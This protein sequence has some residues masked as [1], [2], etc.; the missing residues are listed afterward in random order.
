MDIDIL[1]FWL[2]LLFAAGIFFRANAPTGWLLVSGAIMTAGVLALALAP[3]QAPW[4]ASG[5]VV[6]LIG[7]PSLFSHTLNRAILRQ[8]YDLACWLNRA[9]TILHPMDGT[10]A[11]GRLL[12]A[13]A[14][15]QRGNWEQAEPLLRA[16]SEN[17]MHPAVGLAALVHVCH[18]TGDWRAML[19]DPRL[20][21]GDPGTTVYRL[22]ALGELGRTREMLA[23]FAMEEPRLRRQPGWGN[24]Q[25]LAL[26]FGG[27]PD[28]VAALGRTVLRNSPAE[29]IALWVATA[30]LAT[31]GAEAETG[32]T[33]L[34]HLAASGPPNV[35]RAAELRLANPPQDLSQIH[36]A[37]RVMLDGLSAALL[38]PTPPRQR[39]RLAKSPA[40]LALLA[41]NLAMFAAEAAMGGSENEDVLLRLGAL[42]PHALIEEGEWW[43]LAS[44]MFLHAG[45]IHLAFN[46]LA[47]VLLGGPVEAMFGRTRFLLIYFL[48][49]LGSML[50]VLAITRF[51][52]MNGT[53]LVGA[54]GALMGLLGAIGAALL[55]RWRNERSPAA[56]GRLVFGAFAVAVQTGIDFTTPQISAAAHL[57]GFT[58]GFVLCMA[59]WMRRNMRMPAFANEQAPAPQ[60]P[61]TSR[62]LVLYGFVAGIF[63]TAFWLR[64][65]QLHVTS[66]TSADLGQSQPLT[67]AVLKG[68]RLLRFTFIPFV[69]AGAPVVDSRAPFGSSDAL[70][71]SLGRDRRQPRRRGR[72]LCGDHGGHPEI[73]RAS[74]LGSRP[75]QSCAQRGHDLEPLR[76]SSTGLGSP[77]PRRSKPGRNRGGWHVRLHCRAC[78][79]APRLVLACAR[80]SS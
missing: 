44:A 42:W 28:A 11:Q 72:T 73:L 32:R 46:M 5:L 45:P 4:I 48:S 17:T 39:A 51:G 25:L 75:I 6:G 10:A 33:E 22:R 29:T 43:R 2:A 55:M 61:L 54:S 16:L 47:L 58:I 20:S 7:L 14:M 74:A 26:A 68:V 35:R 69:E 31:G 34:R 56:A 21:D 71:D 66:A 78:R 8:R 1:L 36:P 67:E 41:I 79:S 65:R 49:G 53:L 9:L 59:P 76:R 77:T 23:L 63:G 24:C 3:Q 64:T 30:R 38:A 60:Q 18:W 50:S 57:S 80:H 27:R 13:L 12:R 70:A 37:Q 19:A 15:A 52:W 62:R 40:T